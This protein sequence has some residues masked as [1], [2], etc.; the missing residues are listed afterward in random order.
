M[1]NFR[2]IGTFSKT[3]TRK[4]TK[5]SSTADVYSVTKYDGFV[6]SLDYFKRQVFS[7]DLSTYKIVKQGEFAYSTIHLDEGAIGLLKDEEALISPMYT[8]FKTDDSIDD[9]YLHHLLS[10]DLL[11]NQYRLIG[12]GSLNRRKSI[13]FSIFS[14][15][16]V[17]IPPLE[18]QKKIVDIIDLIDK[19]IVLNDRK[20]QKLK[21]LRIPL[22]EEIILGGLKNKIFKETSCG[23]IP[24]EWE[25][26]RVGDIFSEV[27][28]Y[29]KDDEEQNLY[30]LTLE[31][32]L[33]SKP[34]KYIRDFLI[35]NKSKNNYKLVKHDDLVMNPMNLRF[36]AI[37]AN[38]TNK[39]IL[40]SKY[41]NVIRLKNS[42]YSSIYFECL[43]QS[44]S[45]LKLYDS[46]ATGSLVEKK[47]VHWSD[48]KNIKI[49]LPSKKSQKELSKL[50]IDF[51]EN[52]DNLEQ[53]VIYLKLLKKSIL[54]EILSN[55]QQVSI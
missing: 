38:K 32:G 35:V 26:K 1:S 29:P 41:Y 30:S 25:V 27:T 23:K 18:V 44:R 31:S 14:N 12:Q 45:Y 16:E 53:K 54:T 8:V 10:S 42:D 48:F 24:N 6:R 19:N 46:I 9:N 49:P 28:T 52:L 40:V 39:N 3:L 55:K 50:I 47:R 15:L 20:L 37:A 33:I 11:I 34:K 2:R 4:N 51:N 21:K 17:F 43:F 22:F 36:G 13:S 7:R 5:N